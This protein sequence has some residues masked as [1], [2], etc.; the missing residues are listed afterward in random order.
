MSDEKDRLAQLIEQAK[1]RGPM[2]PAELQQQRISFVYGNLSVKHPATRE[3]IAAADY[4][5]YGNLAEMNDTIARLIEE[6]TILRN[7]A[8]A[9]GIVDD[10]GAAGKSHRKQLTKLAAKIHSQRGEL[11]LNKK[12]IA[13]LTRERDEARTGEDKLAETLQRIAA[14]SEEDADINEWGARSVAHSALASYSKRR[15]G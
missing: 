15:E 6:N 3:S 8:K 10:I 1:A 12:T 9:Q 7:N 4:A 2:T 5:Q 13:R 14:M 11:G